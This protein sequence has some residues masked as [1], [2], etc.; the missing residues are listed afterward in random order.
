MYILIIMSGQCLLHRGAGA[1]QRNYGIS[2]RVPLEEVEEAAQGREVEEGRRE[3]EHCSTIVTHLTRRE[4]ERA[5]AP[6][7][8]RFRV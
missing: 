1:P 8:Q 2:V 7:P 6:W 4:S 5:W 3:Q